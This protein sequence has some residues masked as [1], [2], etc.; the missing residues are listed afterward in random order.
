MRSYSSQAMEFP[1]LLA[2]FLLACVA[3][4]AVAATPAYDAQVIN[5][6]LGGGL[7]V[8]GGGTLLLWGS[9]ATILRS[10]DGASWSHT[11]TPGEADLAC[12]A[13][14][15]DGSV[16]IAVGARGVV[17]RS[18]DGGR[19]WQAARNADD[20]DLETVSFH[21]P[22]GAWIAAGARG[23]ILR[24]TDGGKRWKPLPSP[25]TTDL[26]TS[27][28]DEET[29]R[30]LIGGDGGVVGLSAD[31]GASW[32]VTKIFMPD[33]VTPI[34]GFHRFG[35]RLLATSALGRFLMSADD[36]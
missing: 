30:L 2:W 9:D 23:H 24:S 22:S 33:P 26:H 31:G 4:P 7:A 6:D 18:T 27:F 29:Q 28:V 11:D 12:I 25:L 14:N 15:V 34:T 17:L 13:S 8:P 21:A 5:A 16:L 10:T 35:D 3:C 20:T 1:R 36:G 32:D 19:A